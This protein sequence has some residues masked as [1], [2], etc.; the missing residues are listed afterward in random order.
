MID[1]IASIKLLK[2][3]IA[4]SFIARISSLQNLD[5]SKAMRVLDEIR[6]I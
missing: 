3:E 2:F 5:E 1:D 4:S 6:G